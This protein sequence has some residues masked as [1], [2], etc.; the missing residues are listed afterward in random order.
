MKLACNTPYRTMQSTPGLSLQLEGNQQPPHEDGL[1]YTKRELTEIYNTMLKLEENWQGET[2]ERTTDF[3]EKIN[4]HSQHA[5]NRNIIMNRK[6]R[7]VPSVVEYSLFE[8][9][10]DL[11][12]QTLKN[13][14]KLF[15]HN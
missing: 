9:I 4:L 11:A 8:L 15:K 1:P 12:G 3:K 6:S 14:A 5:Q 13:I 2:L 10:L 7:Q